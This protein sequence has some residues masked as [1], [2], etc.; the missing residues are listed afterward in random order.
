MLKKLTGL[1][2]LTVFALS[3]TY[4]QKQKELDKVLKDAFWTNCPKEFKVMKEPEIW[5]NESAVILANSYEFTLTKETHGLKLIAVLKHSF[6]F[7]VK[8]MD[9]ASIE[10]YS[11]LDFD[12]N[13]S[14]S[15]LSGNTT[16]YRYVGIKIV[17][18]NGEEKE[19]DLSKSVATD[20]NSSSDNKIA[21]PDLEPGDI[22]DYFISVKNEYDAAILS[23]N[24]IVEM[25]LLE[26][27]YPTLYR[28]I[29]YL[30]PN[31]YAIYDFPYN[32]APNFKSNYSGDEA[33]FKFVDTMRAK[34]PDILWN[35]PY[36]TSPEI[37]YRLTIKGY[38]YKDN[39]K[40]NN[41]AYMNG[42]AYVEDYMNKNF[43]KSTD[44]IQ[45]LNELFLM[46][47]SPIY[48]NQFSNGYPLYEP[49]N[50]AGIGKGLTLYISDYLSKKKIAHDVIIVPRRSTGPFEKQIDFSGC[51][52]IVRVKKPK[53]MYF[54]VPVPFRL[55]NEIP[56]ILE[57]MEGSV[58]EF[59]RN[60]SYEDKPSEVMPVSKP[61]DNQS[62][63]HMDLTL[64]EADFSKMKVRREYNVKGNNKQYHQYLIYTNYD[65]LKEYDQP[66]YEQ[67][68]SV[69]VGSVIA[70]FKKERLKFEQRAAQDYLERDKKITDA[71]ESEMSVKVSEYKNFNMKSIGMW[72]ESP[73][74][75]YSDEF[76][77]ENLIKKVGPN[78]MI[79]FGKLL[80]KQV[81]VKGE[82]RVRKVD[83]YMG[84][85]RSYDHEYVFT[86][87]EGYSIEGLENF[88][89]Y[90][91]NKT[92]GFISSAEV[93]D[94]KLTVKTRKYFNENYY[95]VNKWE[96]LL[97]FLDASVE[98]YNA[99]LLLRKN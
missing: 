52:Y 74:T 40:Y 91:I 43:K 24:D 32:G 65:Y 90:A 79:D 9:K 13:R 4:A 49:M 6:H 1:F 55:P 51:E 88:N 68:S 20:Y 53:L 77:I 61:E 63:V 11:E 81:E 47:R 95:P 46:L 67:H 34:A 48:L 70:Q 45:I 15:R 50:Y 12:N 71:I 21:V 19:L 93:K 75:Q 27:K 7:R 14:T 94:G 3:N 16:S 54:A 41:N 23:Y 10:E 60:L 72:P 30:L 36:R 42:L 37:R 80:E 5:K 92:G 84:Y 86:L 39:M 29:Y 89:K 59:Y 83:I 87:P 8:L 22:L 25:E 64:D 33:A 31:R 56:Y 28:S 78:Y 73:T 26:N 35:Y 97:K 69:A 96:D 57:G 99:K 66:K 44:T 17:K 82:D 62:F 58:H 76:T 98:F 85:P 38:N 18:A 2:F